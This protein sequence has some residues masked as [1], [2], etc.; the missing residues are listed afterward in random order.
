MT[1]PYTID[2]LDALVRACVDFSNENEPDFYTGN[3]A[4]R[5]GV[6]P[7]TDSVK[8]MM[9]WVSAADRGIL[10]YSGRGKDNIAYFRVGHDA[11]TFLGQGGFGPYLAQKR[12]KEFIVQA[13]LWAPICIS[14]IALVVSVLA[15]RSPQGGKRADDLNRRIDEINV[16]VDG[17]L[18]QSVQ[19]QAAQEQLRSRVSAMQPSVDSRPSPPKPSETRGK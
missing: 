15:W 19:L 3:I 13:R 12:R 17:A 2:E 5:A 14:L 16:R 4:G 7:D 1:V 8:R 10:E 9:D 11:K 6:S 18:T